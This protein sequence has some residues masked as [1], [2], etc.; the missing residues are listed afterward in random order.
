MQMKKDSSH[1]LQL[2]NAFRVTQ[3]SEELSRFYKLTALIS[4]ENWD[5]GA[6]NL[7]RNDLT[8]IRSQYLTLSL[9][10]SSIIL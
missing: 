2:F 7:L 6:I 5:I 8:N 9:P 3:D 1:K 4:K 10:F